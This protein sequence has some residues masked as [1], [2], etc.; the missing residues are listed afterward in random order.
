MF[1]FC[2]APKNK[3]FGHV[4]VSSGL[5]SDGTT[6]TGVHDALCLF[7]LVYVFS[8][9]YSQGRFHP[10]WTKKRGADLIG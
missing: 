3:G 8:V 1:W 7:F 10:L 2:K 9:T 6:S 5:Y 4:F